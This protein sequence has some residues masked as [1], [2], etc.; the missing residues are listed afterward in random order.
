MLAGLCE[1]FGIVALLVKKGKSWLFSRQC[2]HR[3]YKDLG[4]LCLEILAIP[5]PPSLPWL[6]GI[7]TSQPL[8][9]WSDKNLREARVEWSLWSGICGFL[10]TEFAQSHQLCPLTTPPFGVQNSRAHCS[11]FH[12]SFMALKAFPSP[13]HS[14]Q[15]V[16][17]D[18]FCI[19]SLPFHLSHYSHCWGCGLKL[20]SE[21]AQAGQQ[22]VLIVCLPW[23]TQLCVVLLLCQSIWNSL[24]S[25]TGH[26]LPWVPLLM[27]SLLVQNL[28]LELSA[29]FHF[30]GSGD[31]P[32]VANS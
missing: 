24:N 8:E 14:L 7:S 27:L 9:S 17:A 19:K 13:Q 15:I 4:S 26:S 20:E 16:F 3:F 18:R 32:L 5:R 1:Y 25:F 22:A 30:E 11:H 6:W 28:L 21:F 23:H 31:L 12:G 10:H 2:C 29:Y